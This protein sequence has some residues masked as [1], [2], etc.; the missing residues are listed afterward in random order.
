MFICLYISEMLNLTAR[1]CW[2]FV[3]KDG[4]VAIWQKPFNNSC[5]LN[6]EAGT[7][8]PL[9]DQDDDPDNVWCVCNSAFHNLFFFLRRLSNLRYFVSKYCGSCLIK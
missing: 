6:R 2:D 5:Y 8:P 7:V 3:K 9:C 4:Y 1:L